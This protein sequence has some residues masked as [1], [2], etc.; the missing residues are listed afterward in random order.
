MTGLLVA[1]Q[2]WWLPRK[3]P[4]LG[5]LPAPVTLQSRVNHVHARCLHSADYQTTRTI[6]LGSMWSIYILSVIV[7]MMEMLYIST[8]CH[9]PAVDG[10]TVSVQCSLER[11][12]VCHR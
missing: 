5:M 3:G 8:S 6:N 12:D 9:V 4:H 1:E 7:L 11:H 10:H 2:P